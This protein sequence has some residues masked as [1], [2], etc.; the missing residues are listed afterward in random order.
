MIGINISKE[1]RKGF[2]AVERRR[3]LELLG[4]SD[5]QYHSCMTDK[6]QGTSRGGDR[7]S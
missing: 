6:D 7:T 4:A 3:D 2:T 5:K 1:V